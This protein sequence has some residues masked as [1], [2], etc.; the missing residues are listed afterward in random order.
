[1]S[2]VYRTKARPKILDDVEAAGHVV[3]ESGDLNLN[4]VV[5]RILPGRPNAFDDLLNIIYRESGE[6]VQWYSN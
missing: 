3:F 4:I 6:W 5:T 2:G 1:M